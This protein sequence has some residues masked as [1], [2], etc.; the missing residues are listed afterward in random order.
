VTVEDIETVVL[1]SDDGVTDATFAPAAG[2]VCCSLRHRGEEL[3]A[4]RGG[5]RAYA[6]RGA[7][8]GIPL[9]HPWANRL[10]G[11]AYGTPAHRVELDASSRL[12][13]RDEHGLPIHGVIGSRL[14]W[15]LLERHRESGGAGLEAEMAWEAPELLAVFPFP[16]RLRICARL[17]CASLTIETTLRPSGEEVVPVC[18]GYHPYLTLPG[19]DRRAWQVELPVTRRLLLDE[20]GIPTGAAEPFDAAS[21]TLRESGWDDAFD[22]I[23]GGRA[24][25]VSDDRRRIELRL[26]AGYPYAQVFAPASE[27]FICFEPMTAPTN[28]L[29]S[30]DALRL[31]APGE[32]FRA[33]FRVVV[34]GLG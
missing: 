30:R 32:E 13:R 15:R 3:L 27:S 29:L 4:R 34:H 5:L 14:P 9:L 1:A 16:H 11:T 22:G 10:G 28:A 23:I 6:E 17:A 31:V 25:A 19:S 2:M 12:V 33:A 24:F 8:M 26:L 20:Q 18:F 7:T 21:F